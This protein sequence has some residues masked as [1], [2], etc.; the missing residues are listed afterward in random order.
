MFDRP[1]AAKSRSIQSV[2]VSVA[3]HGA[4]IIA[5]FAVRFS[6]ESVHPRLNARVLLIAPTTPAPPPRL[7]MRTPAKAPQ[8]HPIIKLP[9][10]RPAALLAP[11]LI[12]T[13]AI[14]IKAPPMPAVVAE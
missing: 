14:E 2:I 7:A 11:P 13:P 6:V 5:L 10:P 12:E 1:L 9:P 3:V 4:V 8:F